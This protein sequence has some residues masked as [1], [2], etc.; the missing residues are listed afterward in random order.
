MKKIILSLTLLALSYSVMASVNNDETNNAEATKACE[1]I[2]DELLVQAFSKFERSFENSVITEIKNIYLKNK[3]NPVTSITQ[4]GASFP[5]KAEYSVQAGNDSI[6]VEALITNS[7]FFDQSDLVLT[8]LYF[9]QVDP[10]G[11]VISRNARCRVS[12]RNKHADT[13]IQI[14]LK[15]HATDEIFSRLET[16]SYFQ[17]IRDIVL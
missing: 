17:A 4:I 8:S 14:A 2:K 13:K 10:I 6:E 3:L 1:T 5:A 9:Q 11:R 7:I 12:H 16:V 15:N